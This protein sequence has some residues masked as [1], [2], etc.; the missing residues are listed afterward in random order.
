MSASEGDDKTDT[1][2]ERVTDEIDIMN[3]SVNKT[4]VRWLPRVIQNTLENILRKIFFW[5][6][7]DKRLGGLIR[8]LHHGL[9]YIMFA[10]YIVCHTFVPSY[11]LFV[12]FYIIIILVWIQHL[13]VGGCVLSRLERKFIGD[14]KSFVDPIMEA[15]HIPVTPQS[16]EGFVVLGS[17]GVAAM[18]TFELAA[19]TILNIK[20][21]VSL[22]VEKNS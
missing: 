12:V 17:T 16:T 19:R 15:F 8:F 14:D 9:V 1:N 21:W 13:L 4:H 6:S 22:F 10:W 5:E 11:F 3:E 20:S 2:S 18:L 7:D